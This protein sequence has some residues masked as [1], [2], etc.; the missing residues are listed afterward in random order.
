MDKKMTEKPKIKKQT[1]RPVENIIPP[2]TNKKA[3]PEDV[4]KSIMKA[5]PKEKWG[6]LKKD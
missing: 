6:Y 1:G 5:P 2:L 3:T 4:A